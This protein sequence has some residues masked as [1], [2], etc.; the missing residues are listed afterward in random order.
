MGF[1]KRADGTS[2]EMKYLA[3]WK[4]LYQNKLQSAQEALNTYLA[5]GDRVFI[6]TGCG[7]PRHLLRELKKNLLD[8]H[9]LEFVQGVSLGAHPLVGECY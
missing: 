4:S 3:R 7:E 6:G 9:V 2:P 1:S 5:S 8:Y